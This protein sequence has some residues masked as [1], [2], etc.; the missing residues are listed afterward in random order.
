ML[1]GDHGRATRACQIGP[2]YENH[3]RPKS[4]S[5]EQCGIATGYNLSSSV[6][7]FCLGLGVSLYISSKP[8]A[9]RVGM[10]TYSWARELPRWPSAA[11]RRA[12][13]ALAAA[14]AAGSNSG[15]ATLKTES[16]WDHQGWPE[17]VP[18]TQTYMKNLS[19]ESTLS[20]ASAQSCTMARAEAA[21]TRTLLIPYLNEER[22][23]G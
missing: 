3:D 6:F 17:G 2:S 5:H 11:C 20:S 8:H 4:E 16:G 1:F 13:F 22:N 9:A 19:L 7:T 23:A 18:Q 14:A 10:A 15:T 12:A 21:K